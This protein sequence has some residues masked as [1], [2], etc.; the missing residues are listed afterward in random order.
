MLNKQYELIADAPKEIEWLK[1]YEKAMEEYNLLLDRNGNN[2]KVFQDFFE[3]N[4]S[5]I[6]GAL[7]IFGHS[8]H[9]PYM[10]T[11]ITQPKIGNIMQRIPD[12]LW[13]AQDSLSFCP[14]F[15]EI[16]SPNKRMFTKNKVVTAEFN[17]A[18]NQINEW[19]HIL[20]NPTNLHLFY[21]YFDISK[22]LMKKEFNPQFVLIY[23]RRIEYE[24]EELLR[25]IRAEQRRVNVDIFSYDRLKPISD[26]N[27]FTCTSVKD[28]KYTIKSIP[29]TFR[30][31]ADCAD[32]LY[33]YKGFYDAID[34]ME[35]TSEERKK[36]LKKRYKYWADFGKRGCPGVLVGM[37]GE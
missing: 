19:R 29:P 15:I 28:Y 2:E 1:Y 10:N 25:G 37:E 17:Q 24:E 23:G 12:F 7:E 16:E 22:E 14:V 11:L 21:E 6:P 36:F 20:K 9:Y 26:Y 4:P 31:R 3:K 5:F 30:Y 32:V 8:G 35:K 27:Q 33:K 18:M 34:N 13:L